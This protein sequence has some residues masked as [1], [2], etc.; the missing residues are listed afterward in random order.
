MDHGFIAK[1]AE[2]TDG[3]G[4]DVG[5]EQDGD[6]KKKLLLLRFQV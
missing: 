1:D 4:K 3:E 6:A 2:E 5:E